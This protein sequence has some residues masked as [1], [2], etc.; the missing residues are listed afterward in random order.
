M[1]KTRWIAGFL[2]WVT[3]GPIGA[4]IGYLLGSAVDSYIEMARQ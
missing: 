2:G 4:L 1:A 3:G